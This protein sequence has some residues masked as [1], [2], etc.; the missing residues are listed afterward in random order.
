MSYVAARRVAPMFVLAF[1]SLTACGGPEAPEVGTSAQPVTLGYAPPSCSVPGGSFSCGGREGPIQP[2]LAAACTNERWVG[3]KLTPSPGRCPRARRSRR[4][5]W[6]VHKPFAGFPLTTMPTE[7]LRFCVYEWQP[8]PSYTGAPPIGLLPNTPDMR[9][10]RDCNAVAPMFTPSGSRPIFEAAYASQM[11]LSDVGAAASFPTAS[12]TAIAIVD[13]S[14]TEVTTELPSPGADGH[15]LVV[16]AVARK[17]SCLTS[18]GAELECAARIRSYQGMPLGDGVASYGRPLDVAVA[19]ARAIV[20]WYEWG[21]DDN[22]IINL[23]LGWDAKYSGLHGPDIR[24]TGLAPWLVAQ[25]AV[26]EGAMLVAAAGNRSQAGVSSG[27]MFPGGWEQDVRLCAGPAGIYAPLVHAAG[28]VDGKDDTLRIAR[29]GGNPRLLAPSSFV[30]AASPAPGGGHS[31]GRLVSGTSLSAAGLSGTA[32]LVWALDPALSADEVMEEIYRAATFFGDPPD[33]AKGTGW[34]QA[35]VDS[36]SAVARVCQPAHDN[37]PVACVK[38]NAGIDAQPDYAL[39]FDLEYPGARLGPATP[40][41]SVT[42]VVAVPS[43]DDMLVEP[44]AGPQPGG[45]TCPLCGIDGDFLVGQLELPEYANVV[46]IV[47]RLTPCSPGWC[48]EELGGLGIELEQPLE[49]FKVD[50]GGEVDVNVLDNAM[51][52]VTTETDGKQVVRASELFIN[53]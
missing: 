4:G 37:C 18:G 23:S 28:A 2:D 42:G 45:T 50:I 15:G 48:D 7:L 27:P 40:N 19:M 16:G 36:C 12:R 5:R 6:A 33:F 14:P 53:P 30:T 49:F 34:S 22:L 32:A 9:L 35:R 41:A 21:A 24:M 52:E 8:A 44:H 1:G 51:L 3:Y 38:R 47:L 31:R 43:V 29:P 46:D 39:A 25:W 11:N 26:C 20:D 13:S 17:T 10:E